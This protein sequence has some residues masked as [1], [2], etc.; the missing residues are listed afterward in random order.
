MVKKVFLRTLQVEV[1][2]F[3]QYMEM[4]T[5]SD[6]SLIILILQR[7]IS[8]DFINDFCGGDLFRRHT[9]C[10]N[11]TELSKSANFTYCTKSVTLS[12]NCNYIPTFFSSRHFKVHS[13]ILFNPYPRISI[14]LS[15]FNA[16]SSL[17]PHRHWKTKR[18]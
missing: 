18:K 3:T 8:L 11:T 17:C 4:P 13:K 1:D 14:I 9:G 16:L 2:K 7:P 10:A 5:V 12:L 6:T 15:I